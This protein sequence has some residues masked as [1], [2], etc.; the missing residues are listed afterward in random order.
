MSCR[1][2]VI[3]DGSG[4]HGY[5]EFE[6]S[7]GPVGPPHRALICDTHVLPTSVRQFLDAF[8][9]ELADESSK[10]AS[11]GHMLLTLPE[12]QQMAQIRA[13]ELQEG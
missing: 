1:R 12:L 13:E 11:I 2:V 10:N 9:A 6:L 4:V 8:R 7:S 3:R 5:E